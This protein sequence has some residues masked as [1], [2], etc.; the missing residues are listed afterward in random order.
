MEVA[1]M[2]EVHPYPALTVWAPTP[3][4]LPLDWM[5]LAEKLAQQVKGSVRAYV[6]GVKYDA[7]AVGNLLHSWGLPWQ[8]VMAGYL[9]EYDEEEIRSANL[10][11]TDKVLSH[12]TQAN[13]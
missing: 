12:V 9:W 7:Q 8:V 11:D 10:D 1:I 2:A 13:T 5:A 4:Q 6:L 3:T